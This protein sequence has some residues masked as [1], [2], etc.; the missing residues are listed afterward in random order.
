[1]HGGVF[2]DYLWQTGKPTG[3]VTAATIYP[4]FLRIVTPGKAPIVATTAPM[5]RCASSCSI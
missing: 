5:P 3:A 2:T 4:L 1:V